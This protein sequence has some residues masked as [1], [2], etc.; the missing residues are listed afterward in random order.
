[1]NI[2]E[3]GEILREKGELFLK[4]WSIEGINKEDEVFFIN[5]NYNGFVDNWFV[6][7]WKN[8][9]GKVVEPEVEEPEVE[10]PKEEEPTEDVR[11]EREV[12]LLENYNYSKISIK[13]YFELLDMFDVR[14]KINGT[15]IKNPRYKL[16][17]RKRYACETLIELVNGLDGYEFQR[18]VEIL[19]PYILK[20]LK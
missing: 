5:Y 1:M 10:E 9:I 18:W 4:F 11:E 14:L 20:K 8:R 19:K 15:S 17:S 16:D 2:E 3:I 12:L 6:N 7:N 13:K